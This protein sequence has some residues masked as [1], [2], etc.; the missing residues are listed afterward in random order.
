LGQ[1]TC[2][3]EQVIEFRFWPE[4]A[5]QVWRLAVRLLFGERLGEADALG[6]SDVGCPNDPNVALGSPAR[7]PRA[8]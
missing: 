6:L 5:M 8:S 4:A 7:A 2:A 1:L 3:S